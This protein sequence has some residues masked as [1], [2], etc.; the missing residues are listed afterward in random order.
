[1]IIAIVIAAL[2]LV[3]HRTIGDKVCKGE[4]AD[5]KLYW[6]RLG[7]S[8][9]LIVGMLTAWC[10]VFSSVA[11]RG[12]FGGVTLALSPFVVVFALAYAYMAR[13]AHDRVTLAVVT[14]EEAGDPK[15]QSANPD[16]QSLKTKVRQ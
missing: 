3:L 16:R 5:A 9:A 11:W 4:N 8:G 2:L 13:L 6:W 15:S 10:V 14:G 12:E 1:M 7:T